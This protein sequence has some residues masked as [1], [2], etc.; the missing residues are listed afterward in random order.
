MTDWLDER[1]VCRECG[2]ISDCSDDC[3][4]S[5]NYQSPEERIAELERIVEDLEARLEAV[6]ALVVP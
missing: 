3:S 6:E 4:H 1:G 5:N 2:G